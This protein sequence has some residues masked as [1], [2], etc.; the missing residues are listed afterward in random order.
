MS[1]PT[2]QSIAT[3]MEN[4]LPGDGCVTWRSVALIWPRIF[5]S[6][7]PSRRFARPF[8]LLEWMC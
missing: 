3:R 2:T 7:S 1:A 5:P 6:A 4:S 8:V